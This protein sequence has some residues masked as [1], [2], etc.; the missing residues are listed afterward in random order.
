MTVKAVKPYQS[1]NAT[2]AQEEA[3]YYKDEPRWTMYLG[4]AIG[5]TLFSKMQFIAKK[6][7]EEFGSPWQQVV[8]HHIG[9]PDEYKFKYWEQKGMKKARMTLNRRRQTAIQAMKKQFMRT[10]LLICMAICCV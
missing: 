7:D 10:K 4:T 5:T 3:E 6:K 9:V 2:L 1:R 8:C